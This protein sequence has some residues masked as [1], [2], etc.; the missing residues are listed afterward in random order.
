M[1]DAEKNELNWRSWPIADRP[2]TLLLVIPIGAATL[3]AVYIFTAEIVWIFIAAFILALGL[4]EYFLPLRYTVNEEGLSV[5]YLLWVR[6][7]PWDEVRRVVVSRHGVFLSPFPG[8]SR[9]ESYR[10]LYLRFA[11]NRKEVVEVLNRFLDDS[12]KIETEPR[13]SGHA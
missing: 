12:L 11:N 3:S 7:R 2:R 10:G 9:L 4:R 6:K 1:S 13:M 8:P 5:R